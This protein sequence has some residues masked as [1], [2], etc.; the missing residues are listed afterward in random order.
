MGQS[1]A[2]Q[3]DPEVWRVALEAAGGDVRRL[4]V[5]SPLEVMVRN[6]PAR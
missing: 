3:V 5:R 2:Q 4:E 6:R 1:T